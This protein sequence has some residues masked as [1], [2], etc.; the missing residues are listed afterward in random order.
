VNK[1]RVPGINASVDLI[2]CPRERF[3]GLIG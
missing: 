1:G 3:A 2:R